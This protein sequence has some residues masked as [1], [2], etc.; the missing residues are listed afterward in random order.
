LG[1]FIPRLCFC[2]SCDK[3]WVGL[4]FG[5]FF[6]Q[7]HLVTLGASR[8]KVSVQTGMLSHFTYLSV[9]SKLT[10]LTSCV[11]FLNRPPDGRFVSLSTTALLQAENPLEADDDFC[12]RGRDQFNIDRKLVETC[13]KYYI[14]IPI[15]VTRR[16]KKDVYLSAYLVVH[17]YK[18]FQSRTYLI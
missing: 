13:S 5:R 17:M 1:N 7:T 16:K 3:Q 2:I 9:S 12:R 18:E 4:H 15:I 11:I 8:N 6:S 14:I 10:K